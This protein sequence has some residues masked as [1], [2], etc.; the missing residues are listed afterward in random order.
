MGMNDLYQKQCKDE[1]EQLEKSLADIITMISMLE[2]G[3][4]QYPENTAFELSKYYRGMLK[5]AQLGKETCEKRI[6]ELTEKIE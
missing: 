4:K 6:A 2:I 5:D 3:V 1:K